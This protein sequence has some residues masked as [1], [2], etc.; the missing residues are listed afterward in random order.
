MAQALDGPKIIRAGVVAVHRFENP[1]GAR[2]HRQ[3]QLR[4][5]RRQVAMRG[6][7]IVIHVA[8]M[9]GAVAQAR[10]AGNFR[11]AMHQPPERRCAAARVLAVI[12]VDVL[13]DQ[14]ELAHARAGQA[15][16]LGDDRLDRPRDLHAAR[17]RHDAEGAE[18]VAAL[19]HGDESRHAALADRRAARRGKPVEF[20]LG[21]EF[22]SMI[23]PRS[24]RASISGSR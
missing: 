23:R 5:Q 12:G 4:H 9:A 10:D 16:G 11:K 7:E 14:R 3:M 1:I 21:R 24:A 20:C 8:G 22:R 15:L 6:D 17:V 19:L 2:L 13:A 18:L